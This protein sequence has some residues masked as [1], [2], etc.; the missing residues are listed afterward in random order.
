MKILITGASGFIGNHLFDYLSIDHEVYVLVKKNKVS[1]YQ[2]NAIH[3]DL[4]VLPN[5]IEAF[6]R[7]KLKDIEL[8]I[9]TA[10]ILAD[11]QNLDDINVLNSNNILHYNVAQ[12]AKFLNCKRLINFSSSSVYPNIDGLF[13]E[14]SIPN[15]APNKDAFYGLSKFNGEVILDAQLLTTGVKI[16]HLRCGMIYGEGVNKTRIWPVME[17]ELKDRNTITV[18]GDGKRLINQIHIDQLKKLV[19]KVIEEQ[20]LGIYNIKAETISMFDLAK[21]IS[22]EKGNSE[23]KIILKQEG[24]SLSF[25][26]DCNKL[27]KIL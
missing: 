26:L 12:L 18:F 25:I 4:L 27:E 9:H 7:A 3:E 15:P 14:E 16:T 17:Q 21:R 6:D 24:T 5:L 13:S 1:R 2:K 10:S 8:I 20:L 23:S 19:A 22:H 11:A